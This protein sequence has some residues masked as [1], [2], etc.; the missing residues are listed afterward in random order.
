MS[1]T[2]VNRGTDEDTVV[3]LPVEFTKHGYHF[4]QLRRAENKAIY[5]QRY[6]G[7]L[8]A[9]EIVK[10]RIRPGGFNQL[11]GKVEPTREVYPNSE[12][13]GSAGWTVCDKEKALA[14]YEAL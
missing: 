11:F 12:Q 9:Y 1:G 10:I 5:E 13:W 4:T 8:L 7:R 3:R 2:N 6:E 14:K